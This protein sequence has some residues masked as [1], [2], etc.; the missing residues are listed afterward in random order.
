MSAAGGAGPSEGGEASVPPQDATVS[1]R[2]FLDRMAWVSSAAVAGT[3]LT[4]RPGGLSGRTTVAGEALRGVRAP[5]GQ[6]DDPTELTLAETMT[7]LR[8][9]TLTPQELVRAHADRIER[10]DPVYQAYAARPSRED[11][12]RSAGAVPADGPDAA[13]RGVCLAPKDNF[14]TADLLTEGGSLVF[15]GFRPE[16]DATAV[17]LGERVPMQLIGRRVRGMG[18]PDRSPARKASNENAS[19]GF[20]LLI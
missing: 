19:L 14:Y 7:A 8:A 11:L 2:W 13:L 17:A 18:F 3:L 5:L 9:G 10:F 4:P 1:R 16:Y 6:V 12:L 20:R 15:E